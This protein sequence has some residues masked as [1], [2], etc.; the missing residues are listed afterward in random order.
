MPNLT[1]QLQ[2]RTSQRLLQVLLLSMKLY[3]VLLVLRLVTM[4]VQ[5]LSTGPLPYR[6]RFEFRNVTGRLNL[7]TSSEAARAK[8][9]RSSGYGFGRRLTES[10]KVRSVIF[11]TEFGFCEELAKGN[12]FTIP[13]WSVRDCPLCPKPGVG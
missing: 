10:R 2:P 5:C 6:S 7:P 3:V 4:V 12:H 1:D 9:L 13:A 11:L 8:A